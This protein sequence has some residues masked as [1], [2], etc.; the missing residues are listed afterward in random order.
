MGIDDVRDV[1]EEPRAGVG[2]GD[3][4]DAELLV[5]GD[6]G[7]VDEGAFPALGPPEEAFVAVDGLLGNGGQEGLVPDLADVRLVGAGLLGGILRPVDDVHPEVLEAPGLAQGPVGLEPIAGVFVFD[8]LFDLDASAVV[9]LDQVEGVV[10]VLGLEVDADDLLPAER[11]QD[12]RRPEGLDV[13]GD[14]LE[15]RRPEIE[16]AHPQAGAEGVQLP[17]ERRLGVESV[18]Q[19]DILDLLELDGVEERLLGDLADGFHGDTSLF[20]W[21]DYNTG[22]PRHKARRGRLPGPLR[23]PPWPPGPV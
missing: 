6:R 20:K 22:G 7:D 1:R 15:G 17:A 8:P 10:L 11:R 3:D 16:L 2:L 18:R 9:L 21:A 19:H 23:G 12:L 4:R 14:G 13:V 5:P